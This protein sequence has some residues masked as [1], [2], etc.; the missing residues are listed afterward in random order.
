MTAARGARARVLAAGLLGAAGLLASAA[1]G[2]GPAAAGS[3]ASGAAEPCRV[4]ADYADSRVGEFPAGWQPRDGDAR[5]TYRVLEEGG[6]RFVR[7]TAQGTGSQMGREFDWDVQAW[8]VLRWDWRPRVFP[9]RAD[10]RDSATNDSVMAVYAVFG[11]NQLT[12][13]AVKWVWSRAVPAGATVPNGRAPVIVLRS[14]P[15]PDAG[16]VTETVDVERDY[17]RLFDERAPRARGIAVLTDSDQTRSRAVGDYGRFR[18]CPAR[19]A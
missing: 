7:A 6:V 18:I 17:R 12:G 11:S 4:V 19:P 10:E 15:A 13:R 9:A 16:W 3:G 5:E 1:G 8:P 2:G 14:G